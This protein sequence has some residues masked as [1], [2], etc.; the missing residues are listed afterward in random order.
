MNLVNGISNFL[1]S[2]CLF[3]FLFVLLF[4]LIID[5]YWLIFL[6]CFQFCSL[7]LFTVFSVHHCRLI[8]EIINILCNNTNFSFIFNNFI[9]NL[10]NTDMPDIGLTFNFRNIK[11]FKPIPDSKLIILKFPQSQKFLRGNP[12]F[13]L[14]RPISVDIPKSRYSTS[15]RYTGSSHY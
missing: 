5:F 1:I 11:L 8:M 3:L 2:L 7:L 15:S 9:T 12:L 14:L 13:L 10:I 6:A 4:Q